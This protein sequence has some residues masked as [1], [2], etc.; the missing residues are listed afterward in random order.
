MGHGGGEQIPAW[1]SPHSSVGPEAAISHPG[2]FAHC[3]LWLLF[4]RQ[5]Q[6]AES[7]FTLAIQHN[8]QMAQYYLHRARSRQFIQNIFGARQDVATALI[9]DPKQPKVGSSWWPG[10]RL[11]S[12]YSWPPNDSPALK[13][14]VVS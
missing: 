8:P 11:Q 7:H 4:C 2:G 3:S 10:G 9:L 13:R 14:N 1:F 5:F 6:K 12:Q